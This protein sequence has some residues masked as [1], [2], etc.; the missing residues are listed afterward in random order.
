MWEAG[1][2][3]E[4]NYRACSF[5]ITPDRVTNLWQTGKVSKDTA[6]QEYM[7]AKKHVKAYLD[8]VEF[9]SR[10]ETNFALASLGAIAFARSPHQVAP[11]VP[12][13]RS[14]FL[15]RLVPQTVCPH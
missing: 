2:R 13:R 15:R 14:S 9:H 6:T 1:I 3:M 8:N 10:F 12:W 5:P 7:R 11:T 4:T